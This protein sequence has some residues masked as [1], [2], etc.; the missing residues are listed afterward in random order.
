MAPL[1]TYFRTT[2]NSH[3]VCVSFH[4]EKETAKKLFSSFELDITSDVEYTRV[5]L[6]HTL[7]CET[8]M[9]ARIGEHIMIKI[10]NDAVEHGK[11]TEPTMILFPEEFPQNLLD[12]ELY[13]IN[14]P[15]WLENLV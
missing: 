4:Y 8:S 13:E 2:I 7:P 1:G 6:S 3:G 14:N 10:I 11:A 9:L 5:V 12:Y 15:Q